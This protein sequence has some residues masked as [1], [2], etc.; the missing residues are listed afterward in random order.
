[1]ITDTTHDKKADN[2]LFIKYRVFASRYN[3]SAAF[4]QIIALSKRF[5]ALEEN[6]TYLSLLSAP[7][8]HN[9]SPADKSL[10][11]LQSNQLT[12]ISY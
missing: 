8:F 11:I 1:M 3:P 7:L 6:Q 5:T 10:D 2:S 12:P 4:N 9:N